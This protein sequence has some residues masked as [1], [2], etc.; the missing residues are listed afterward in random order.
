MGNYEEI[1]Q[2]L[3]DNFKQVFID[4]RHEPTH[5]E[6]GVIDSMMSSLNGK[7]NVFRVLKWIHR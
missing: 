6:Y 2:L 3:R 7:R 5:T 4:H 1:R